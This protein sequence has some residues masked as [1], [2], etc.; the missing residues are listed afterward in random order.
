MHFKHGDKF[1]GKV[2]GSTFVKIINEAK[3]LLWSKGGVPCIDAS[4]WYAIS[5][6]VEWIEVRGARR[7]F[8][9]AK[10]VFDS[11]KQEIDFGYGKQYFVSL[12]YWSV[13][14]LETTGKLL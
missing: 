13:S 6:R 1:V 10:D 2:V 3:H 8:V 11:Q 9:I 12:E 14:E 5:P 4:T 7:R